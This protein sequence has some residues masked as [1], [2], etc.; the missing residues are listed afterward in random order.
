MQGIC[1]KMLHLTHIWA[2]SD[3]TIGH[4]WSKNWSTLQKSFLRQS[5]RC[6]FFA[7]WKWRRLKEGSVGAQKV[8]QKCARR[9]KRAMSLVL[10]CAHICSSFFRFMRTGL[11]LSTVVDNEITFAFRPEFLEHV[12][13]LAMSFAKDM[14][15]DAVTFFFGLRPDFL[16]LSSRFSRCSLSGGWG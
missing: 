10:G 15:D 12:P 11:V 7:F 2:K 6:L 8:A 1:G 3:L 4:R 13:F 5:T 14:Q 16:D 9:Y